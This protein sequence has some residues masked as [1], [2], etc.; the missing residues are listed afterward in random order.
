MARGPAQAIANR[1]R[2]RIRLMQAEVAGRGLVEASPA[3]IELAQPAQLKPD[4]HLSDDS[5][6]WFAIWNEHR[7]IAWTLDAYPD[8]LVPYERSLRSAQRDVGDHFAGPFGS[9]QRAQSV[10]VERLTLDRSR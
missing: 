8:E 10:A 7:G 1:C 5:V 9:E 2:Q 4:L 3:F 6:V